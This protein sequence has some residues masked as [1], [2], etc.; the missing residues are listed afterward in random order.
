MVGVEDGA[1]AADVVGVVGAGV[2]R[3]VEH[4]VEPGP[5]PAGL[6]R[7]VGAALQLGRLAQRGLADVLGQVGLFDPGPVVVLLGG[8][9]AVEGG[10]FLADRGELLAQQELALLLL[11]ALADVV[12]DRLGDVELGELVAR[13]A[14]QL[15]QPLL[16]R[17]PW[18]SSSLRCS[19]D[20]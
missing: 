5:D 16:G 13:P 9:R 12:A 17:R 6:G 2:P 10:Q 1:G 14:G 18:L 20:R 3:H 19:T 8:R 4:G 7:A 15:L 11:H